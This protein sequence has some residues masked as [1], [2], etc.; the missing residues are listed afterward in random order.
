MGI[1]KKRF[2]PSVMGEVL[3][4]AVTDSSSQAMRERGLRP[5]LQPKIEIVSFKEG[6]DLEYKMALELLPDIQ[7]VD[8]ASIKL[9]RLRPEIPE[10][11]V[12]EALKR[13]AEPHRKSEK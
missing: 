5:A 1:L 11:D 3:E 12:E 9:E 7:P 8:L 10:S 6:A 4:N 2:G 13:I